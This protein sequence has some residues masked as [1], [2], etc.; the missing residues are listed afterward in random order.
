[1]TQT[2]ESKGERLLPTRQFF[3]DR[4]WVWVTGILF[5]VASVG[6]LAIWTP[7]GVKIAAIWEAPSTLAALSTDVAELRRQAQRRGLFLVATGRNKR[8]PHPQDDAV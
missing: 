3:L 2:I 6:F 4:L 5:W 7:V 8:R 1:M